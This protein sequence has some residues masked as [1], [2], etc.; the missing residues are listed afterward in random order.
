MIRKSSFYLV[1]A[2]AIFEQIGWL[3]AERSC[4]AVD[5][6]VGEKEVEEIASSQVDPWM[7]LSSFLNAV[8]HDRVVF[9]AGVLL[10]EIVA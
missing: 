1:L 4:F 5:L 6:L 7:C 8:D 2:E 10:V 3:A 9:I